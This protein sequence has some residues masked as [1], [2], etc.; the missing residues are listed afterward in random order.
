MGNQ[1]LE[2]RLLNSNNRWLLPPLLLHKLN[3]KDRPN[4]KLL[5]PSMLLS[6]GYFSHCAIC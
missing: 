2:L 4:E 3:N 1:S 5:R 6:D